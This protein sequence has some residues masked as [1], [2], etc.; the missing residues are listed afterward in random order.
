MNMNAPPAHEIAIAVVKRPPTIRCNVHYIGNR[1]PLTPSPLIKLPPGAITPRGWLRTQLDLM[2]DGLTGRLP[3]VSPWCAKSGSAWRSPDGQGENGWEELPY[4]LRGYASLG[5]VLK[6]ERMIAETRDWID[7]ILRTQREDG[8]FGPR[9]NLTAAEG[10]APGWESLGHTEQSR[11]CP[12]VW[13][14]MLVLN[15]LQTQFDATGDDRVLPF[16]SRYFRWQ[17][18]LPREQLLPASWQKWRAGD[19][20]ESVHWLYNR[21]GEAWLLEHARTI[22]AQASRWDLE[23]PTWHGVNIC[24]GFREPAEYF[25]QSGERKLLDAT[26]RV[27]QT[28][29]TMFGQMPGG[30]FAADENCRPG[31]TDPRNA[32]ETCSMVELMHSFEMLL[33]ISGDPLCADRCE[34]IAF[35]SLPA[36]MTPKLD[37]LHYLTAPNMVQLDCGNKSPALE[38]DGCMLA[39]SP[40]KYRCCQHNHSIGWPYFAEHLWMAT[41]DN[42]VA[43][44]MYAANDV[45]VR[46]GDSDDVTIRE[47]TD[48]PFDETVTLTVQTATPARFPL[49]LRIPDWASRAQLFVNGV[50]AADFARPGEF[51]RVERS[52]NDGDQ[53]R[54]IFDASFS[55]TS[56]RSNGDGVSI[57]RGPLWYALKIGE[58]WE[59]YGGTDTWPEFEV[60]PTTPWNYGLVLR[61]DDPAMGI[62]TQRKGGPIAAQPFDVESSPLELT[63]EARRIPAWTLDSNGLIGE[64][65]SSPTISEEPTESV[66]LIPMGCARLRISVFPVIGDVGSA[67]DW[68]ALAS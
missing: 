37:G 65:Q 45:R 38:N 61:P 29:L 24:Q 9:K 7:A 14:N 40:H 55:V 16:M 4:W 30:M 21:T 57:R 53:L 31:F 5:Y 48:Y 8:Y 62:R 64:F 12:D 63:V 26:E 15:V 49:Y 32:A 17:A 18:A 27:Y 41:P 39:Y 46:V 54:L 33:A 13:P 22:H 56:W 3:E 23:I 52:W 11:R 25:V 47:E 60:F 1:S 42:G 34:E 67:T 50:A 35:N 59:R 68:R 20:L 19:N 6:N 43:A 66:R 51:I 44:T 28:V 58:R 10:G 2:R 36:S